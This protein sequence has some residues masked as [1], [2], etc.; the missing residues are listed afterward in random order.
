MTFGGGAKPDV[1][2]VQ[3]WP[4]WQ[5]PR[6]VV[7]YVLALAGVFAAVTAVGVS[8]TQLTLPDLAHYAGLLACAGVCVEASRQLGETAGLARGL[9]SAWT[10]PIALL[11]PPVYGLLAPVPLKA[12]SQCRV[13]R[14][15][16]HR[17]VLSATAL[18]L[19]HY[20]ASAVFHRLLPAGDLGTFLVAHP[21]KTVLTAVGCAALD[22]LVNVALV[23][24]AVR[25]ATPD[26]D[27]RK[28]LLDQEGIFIDVVEVCVG[29]TVFAACTVT[30]LLALLLLPPVVFLQRGLIYV[31]LRTSSRTDAKTGLLNAAAWQQEADREIVRAARERHS[32]AVLMIDLDH[33]KAFNDTHGHLAG[34]QALKAV[35]RCLDAGL[36][37]YDQLGRFGGEEFTVVLPNADQAE[38]HRIAE[39]LRRGVADL[40]IPGI[41]PGVRLTISLGAAVVGANGD[42]LL[43][44]LAAADH[45][46]YQAKGRGRNQIAFAPGAPAPGTPA[47]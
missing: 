30:S 10:L 39:R 5:L 19:A 45:A 8:S 26:V 34:D 38:A 42:T 6:A 17:R 29:V 20:S 36:R 21:T 1:T 35:S 2:G 23:T 47:P 15:L 24:T 41:D 28:I 37:G 16:L 14:S 12:L 7:G 27:W 25:L 44:L 31:Q 11:L 43:D 9:Q 32:L 46:L 3:Q 13:G 18:G 4:L 40:A 33:F 22:Y